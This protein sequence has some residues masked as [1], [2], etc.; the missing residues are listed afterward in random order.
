MKKLSMS[1]DSLNKAMEDPINPC[2]D[3]E[4]TMSEVSV[5]TGRS[6]DRERRYSAP[7]GPDRRIRDSVGSMEYLSES[8]GECVCVCMCV[9]LRVR[10]CV[11]VCVS[12]S[13]GECVCECVQYTCMYDMVSGKNLQG[14][15]KAHQKTFLG[16]GGCV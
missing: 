15:A 4:P 1:N 14:G 10:V 3:D 7:P 2:D 12:E 16:G 13:Q 11:C 5:R 6:R 9:C 8:Q